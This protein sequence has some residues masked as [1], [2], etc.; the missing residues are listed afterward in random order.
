M[1]AFSSRQRCNSGWCAYYYEYYFLKDTAAPGHTHDWEHI[2]VW[3]P[4]DS[5][6]QKWVCASAH[7]GWECREA[8]EVRW[9]NGEHPKVIESMLLVSLLLGP[10]RY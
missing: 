10:L 9:H 5:K 3:V 4:D 8:S 1:T 2:I 6:T 7:G